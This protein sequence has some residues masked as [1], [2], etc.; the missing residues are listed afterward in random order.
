MKNNDKK[1]KLKK[2]L[3]VII[4]VFVIAIIVCI[5]LSYAAVSFTEKGNKQHTVKTGTLI[6]SLGSDSDLNLTSAVPVSD[7]NGLAS[8]PYTFTVKNTGSVDSKYQILIIDDDEKYASDNCANKKMP[9]EDI[10]YNLSLDTA[11][12]KLNSGDE[13]NTDEE[14]KTKVALLP[15]DNIL[16]EDIIKKGETKAYNLRVWISSEAGNEVSDTHFHSRI[17]VK[18]IVS[19]RNNFDTGE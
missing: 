13:T 4:V 18:A 17:K 10:K 19:D 16:R 5:G 11:N 7:S 12:S 14:D 6:V 15:S 1:D 3:P 8:T 9:W 2:A